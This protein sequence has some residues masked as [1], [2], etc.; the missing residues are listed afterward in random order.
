MIIAVRRRA[1]M[2]R[3][4]PLPQHAAN[5]S[6]AAISLSNSRVRETAGQIRPFG[7]A[8]RRA[9]ARI[10]ARGDHQE[11]GGCVPSAG[12]LRVGADQVGAEVLA[13]DLDD[14]LRVVGEEEMT[15][16][17]D[18]QVERS[19]GLRGPC[20]GLVHGRLGIVVTD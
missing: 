10:G 11:A 3:P 9:Q 4:A 14:L 18:V 12:A 8:P 7:E 1:P 17:K 5:C 19:G 20:L 13:E 16:G 15:A 2:P 6:T